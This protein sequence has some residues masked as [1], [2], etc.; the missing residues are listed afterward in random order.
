MNIESLIGTPYAELDCY[1]LVSRVSKEYFG[2][3]LPSVADYSIDPA[4]VVRNETQFNKW[5]EL[6]E[7][8][9]GAI[10]VLGINDIDRR[11]VGICLPDKNILHTC[12]KYGAIIQSLSQLRMTGYYFIRYY[13]WGE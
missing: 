10:A 13:R 8:E 2:T 7:Y 9:V 4:S 11:H 3:Q 6:V 12:K 1:A 5:V